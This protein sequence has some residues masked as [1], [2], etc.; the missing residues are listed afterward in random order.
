LVERLGGLGAETPQLLNG[1]QQQKILF[2]L[3]MQSAA[4]FIY[5]FLGLVLHNTAALIQLKYF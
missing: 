3:S 2:L 4:R 1:I 5:S